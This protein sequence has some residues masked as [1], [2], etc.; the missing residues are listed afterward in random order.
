NHVA[1]KTV[2]PRTEP[3]VFPGTGPVVG[4]LLELF[5]PA[6]AGSLQ[7]QLIT[8]E[9]PVFGILSRTADPQ[10][11]A[12]LQTGNVIKINNL[13]VKLDA[14]RAP[15]NFI[16]GEESL[17]PHDWVLTNVGTGDFVHV[18]YMATVGQSLKYDS[19]ARTLIDVTTG[20]KVPYAVVDAT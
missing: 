17:Y 16:A 11:D 2:T 1:I 9:S 10:T 3:N 12:P 20:L 18:V 14:T 13:K 15:L 6:L 19:E 4:T 5:D 8:D 7:N